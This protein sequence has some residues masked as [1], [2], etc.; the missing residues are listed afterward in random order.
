MA[1]T[2]ER[3]IQL[4]RTASMAR[5]FGVEA[6]EIGLGEAVRRWPLMRT[7]DLTGAVWLP[8]DGKGNP[9]YITAALARG[10]RAGGV[11]IFEKTRADG[12]AIAKSCCRCAGGRARETSTARSW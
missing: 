3:L 10:A 9:A 2:A 11:H 1:R 12:V 6:E 4:K 8:G 5:G 7:D